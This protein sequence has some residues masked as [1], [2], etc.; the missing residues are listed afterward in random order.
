MKGWVILIK[1]CSTDCW[2]FSESNDCKKVWLV[3]KFCVQNDSNSHRLIKLM[4]R[5]IDF[6]I[7]ILMTS[8]M[9][10]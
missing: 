7:N 6:R 9:N 8:T 10:L 2:L 3:F 5:Y 1:V 4:K